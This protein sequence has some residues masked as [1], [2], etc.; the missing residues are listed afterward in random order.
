M[1]AIWVQGGRISHLDTRIFEFSE[2]FEFS[3]LTDVLRAH[4]LLLAALEYKTRIDKAFLQFSHV[5]P[6]LSGA[7]FFY[8][9]Y[10]GWAVF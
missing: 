4:N 5:Q 3:F 8:V 10:E 6:Y 7:C 2:K 9:M 1:C